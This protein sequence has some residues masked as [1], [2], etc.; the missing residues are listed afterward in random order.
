MR[1]ALVSL[2]ALAA[3]EGP[4]GPA[5]PEGP[6]GPDGATGSQGSQGD[7]GSA[8]TPE[9]APWLTADQVKIA[10][11][12]LTFDTQGAHVAFTL[13]DGNGKPLDRTGTLTDGAVGV[14]FVLAQLATQPDGSPGQYTAYTTRIQT[15]QTPATLGNTAVQATTESVAA[16]FQTVDVTQ[17]TYTY[18]VKAALTGLDPTLTQTV[19]AVARRTTMAGT[20]MDR[21]MLSARPDSGTPIQRELVTDAACFRCHKALDA[22]GGQYTSPNNCILCHT[23]QSSDPDTGNTVDFKVML[24]K[25][26]RGSS[27][28][29]PY[30]IIGYQQSVNE[31][32]NV[33]FPQ[34]L[35]RC[36]ACHD[37][38]AAQPD[39]WGTNPAVAQC[40]S[41]HDNI[42][43][44]SPVPAGY[45]LHSG[46]TQPPN[47]QCAVCH[48]LT[49]SIAGIQDKHFV[50]LLDPAAP[51]L[52]LDQLTVT[53]GPPTLTIQFRAQLSGA[54]LDILTSPLTRLSATV[55]GN[56]N[57]EDSAIQARIQ[58][59]NTTSGPV[60]TLTAVDAANGIFQYV[61]PD[62]VAGGSVCTNVLGAN[63]KVA[64]A[65]PASASGTYEVGLEGYTQPVSGGPRYASYNPTATFAVT[66][67][68]QPRRDIVDTQTRC[69]GCHYSLAA[70]GGSRTNTDYCVF[71][72]NT[73][74]Q[75][76][77]ALK[78]G[79]S[80]LGFTLDLRS[81]VHK[82]HAGE[83]LTQGYK[84]GNS[85]F[86]TLAYPQSL[87]NCEACHTSQ[88]W[89]LDALASSTTYKPSQQT[90]FTCADAGT[91]PT[92]ACTNIVQTPQPL[93]P[94]TSVCTSCHDA[95]Y[96]LAHA[97]TNT[98]AAG[99]E[100]CAACHGTGMLFD[101]KN[102]HG[103]P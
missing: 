11:T 91:D 84:I 31:W 75:S 35:A 20:A 45:V 29:F 42:S 55:A 49:G 67:T 102:F 58:G 79:Q 10:V 47:A 92:V 53:S 1:I 60:G 37:P 51:K 23:P 73:G 66:G 80:V 50:G 22:H 74:L 25:I 4:A 52:V 12:G 43:F 15:S 70:H 94:M 36:T 38:A 95:P 54:P 71:C 40:T 30:E 18:T 93:P 32:S 65:L 82:I 101:V 97:Q 87:T 83:N 56:T 64:C 100:A 7:Q 41:C 5:G 2:L 39:R 44:V 13:T 59:T 62:P 96:T 85:D 3:C 27:L 98:T 21:A 28:T 61:F 77:V 72:H 17:G 6:P 76:A 19:L 48:P 103:T 26:H 14:S 69:D 78:Q 9:P 24:H 86:S 81:M 68:L 16:N 8:G 88:N 33:E 34:D 99:A 90:L 63:A 46:G 89:T 57:D